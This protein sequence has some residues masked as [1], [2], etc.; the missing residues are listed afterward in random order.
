[1]RNHPDPQKAEGS[2]RKEQTC[3]HYVWCRSAMLPSATSP[4]SK[5]SAKMPRNSLRLPYQSVVSPTGAMAKRPRWQSGR[6]GCKC[7]RKWPPTTTS[8]PKRKNT[9]LGTNA[10]WWR[11]RLHLCVHGSSP[12]INPLSHFG[13]VGGFCCKEYLV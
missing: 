3:T 7:G 11:W 1:M 2:T 8:S 12:S 10:K 13:V 5:A 4:N 9:P 6:C